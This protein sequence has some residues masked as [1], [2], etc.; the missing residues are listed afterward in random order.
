MTDAKAVMFHL[1]VF[2]QGISK[3]HEQILMKLRRLVRL[4]SRKSGL[5]FEV[6]FSPDPDIDFGLVN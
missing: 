6:Q 5:E 1:F 2:E 4:G 3:S